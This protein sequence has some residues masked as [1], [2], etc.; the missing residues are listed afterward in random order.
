MSLTD[1]V[2]F[3]ENVTN[4]NKMVEVILWTS[5]FVPVAF[6]LIT[7]IGLWKVPHL[8]SLV[9]FIFSL[10]V[11]F[12]FHLIL[13]KEEF[14]EFGMYF[15]LIACSLF[16]MM[17]AY[18]GVIKVTIAYAFAPVIS[19]L[20]YNRKFSNI[21]TIFN[22]ILLIPVFYLR[23]ASVKDVYLGLTPRV[24]WFLQNFTGL[25]VEFSFLFLITNYLTK[26]THKTLQTLMLSFDSR[27]KAYDKLKEKNREQSETQFKI[28][29]FVSQ[30]LA[31]HDLFTGQHIIH[32]R[33]YVEIIAK[34][35]RS[36]G[37]YSEELT[38]KNI[39]IYEKAAILHDIGKVHIPEGILNKQGKFTNEEFELMKCHPEEGKKLLSFLPKIDDG[40]F[41]EIAIQ[42]AYFHHEKW[43]GSG[44]PNHIS[45]TEIPLCARIMAAADV[46]DALISQRLYKDPMTVEEAM[47]VFRKSSGSHFEPCIAQAVIELKEVIQII[48]QDFKISEAKTNEKELKWWLQYHASTN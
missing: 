17:L 11:S 7:I 2:F 42:M 10:S 18:K 30:I 13:K 43:D 19:C 39:E 9:M 37:Y 26:R 1:E 33:K 29:E 28:M 25:M 40:T 15:G 32:T 45:C 35:L 38:D 46:L 41:N 16:V 47:D 3:K 6:F 36:S 8:Y 44:Y 21:I 24:K 48:D 20:Y 23:S 14:Q 4:V 34:Q 12:V 27:N 31:S 22:F 5:A